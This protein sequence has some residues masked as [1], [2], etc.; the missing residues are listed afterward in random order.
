MSILGLVRRR[1]LSDWKLLSSILVGILIATS[2][3]S[4]TPI[5]LSA[6]EQQGFITSINEVSSP[7]LTINMSAPNILVSEDSI[8][9]TENIVSNAI[10][11]YL[12]EIHLSTE[13]YIK[14]DSWLVGFPSRP[15]PK[16]GG[17]GIIASRGYL[18]SLTDIQANSNFIDGR[19]ALSDIS[20]SDYGPVIEAVISKYT[21]IT[22]DAQIGDV[23]TLT[24]SLADPIELSISIVGIIE[25]NDFNSEYWKET[26][27]LLDPDPLT[28]APPLMVQV[29]PDEP[30]LALFVTETVIE[31]LLGNFVSSLIIGNEIYQTSSIFLAGTPEMPLP[32]GGGQG[33]LSSVGHM[34]NISNLAQNSNFIIGNMSK[35]TVTTGPAGPIVEVVVSGRTETWVQINVGDV[36]TLSPTFGSDTTISAKVVGII[37]PDNATNPYWSDAGIF[38]LPSGGMSQDES[39]EPSIGGLTEEQTNSDL[40]FASDSSTNNPFLVQRDG[41]ERPISLL[42]TRKAMAKAVASAYPGTISNMFWS[43][44]LNKEKLKNWSV[45]ETRDNLRD[46]E[47]HILQSIP[48]S[49]VNSGFVHGVTRQG[50]SKSTISKVPLLLIMTVMTATAIYL[51]IMM[52]AYLVQSR[53]KDIARLLTRGLKT[54]QFAKL[55]TLEGITVTIVGVTLAP[56]I[57]MSLVSL[58]G[59][60]PF[61][62]EITL[63]NPLPVRFDIL[64]Y[65]LSFSTG[66]ACLIIMVAPAIISKYSSQFIN[67]LPSSR[68]PAI[69]W[70]HNNNLDIGVLILGGLAFWEFEKRG[71]IVSG[72]LFKEANVN[73][74]LLLAPVLFLIA[75]GLIFMR[76]FPITMKFI[77]GESRSLV[78]LIFVFSISMLIFGIAISVINGESRSAWILAELL[79]ISLA[80]T[81]WFTEKAESSISR[82]GGIIV[83]ATLIGIFI[84]S[85][86]ISTSEP[87]FIPKAGLISTLPGQIIFPITKKIIKL[88]PA[89]LSISLWYMARVPMQ[90]TWI[91]LLL[92]LVTGMGMLSNTVGS[93]LKRS[94]IDQAL[95]EIPSD[96]VVRGSGTLSRNQ[97]KLRSDYES[98]SG[99]KYVSPSIRQAASINTVSTEILGVESEEF[100]NFAWYRQDFSSSATSDLFTNLKPDNVIGKLDIPNDSVSIGL[101]LNPIETSPFATF[102]VVLGYGDGSLN[103]LPLVG[104]LDRPGWNFVKA[105]IPQNIDPPFHIVAFQVYEPTLA[106]GTP[107]QILIDGI[108]VTSPRV[109]GGILLEGFENDLAWNPIET[110]GQESHSIRIVSS[111]SYEGENSGL[112]S[113]GNQTDR[114]LRGMYYNPSGPL[115]VVFSSSLASMSKTSVGDRT[116][117]RIANRWILVEIVGIVDYFPTVNPTGGG[118][119]IADINALL[120]HTNVLL[121]SYS[122]KPNAAFIESNELSHIDT[123]KALKE[124]VGRDIQV[125][126]VASKLNSIRLDPFVSAGWKPMQIIA[127]IIGTLAAAVGYVTYLLLFTKRR[128]GEMGALHVIGFSKLQMK[129]L[130]FFEHLTI[131]VIGIGIGTWAG[132]FMSKSLVSSLSVTERGQPIIPPFII[133]ID[134]TILSINYIALGLVFMTSLYLVNRQMTQIKLHT[135]RE[136]QDE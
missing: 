69:S 43:I 46:F 8:L 132:S 133:T 126:D 32:K 129:A 130:L 112:L 18:Q 63:G 76:L 117:A 29:D 44:Q 104:N 21:A 66:L 102:F 80:I 124:L 93:T 88:V 57:A 54:S 3:A 27:V 16:G 75:I 111:D 31:Q 1:I 35:D 89:W 7:V 86:G 40:G 49:S 64:P 60:L 26:R 83:Q 59:V 101:W 115:P 108:H 122:L 58:A 14:T 121:E 109:A 11:N 61:F 87:F 71:N 45:Q 67:I 53:D 79:L 99:V 65:I 70:L 85:D 134:W 78:S 120:A 33:V 39:Y 106:Q 41:G 36:L 5:Y 62:S 52:I 90:Y 91:I 19:M 107:G 98:V 56:L 114:G 22:F 110:L 84:I 135:F 25:P 116:I 81:Y 42:V 123:V 28:N 94:E 38:I 119:I 55:Y 136:I 68:P 73:E 77:A 6:L 30:P 9:D 125:R 97:E 12:K 105:D 72:G 103:T 2:L 118:F 82:L 10:D 17:K 47:D 74:I 113:F 15:L 100:F 34:V 127:P 128:W 13:T 50:Q 20:F 37:E 95:Y 92:I 4:G 48:G 23:F 24:S 96:I 131:G 51:L